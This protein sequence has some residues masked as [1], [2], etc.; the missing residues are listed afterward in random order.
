MLPTPPL[1]CLLHDL[2]FHP[3]YVG[4]SGGVMI[5]GRGA[6]DAA[7]IRWS[8]WAQTGNSWE[9]WQ[10]RAWSPTRE[11]VPP[12]P[13]RRGAERIIKPS[14]KTEDLHGSSC[15]ASDGCARLTGGALPVT[16][17]TED[18]E[19]KVFLLC[20]ATRGDVSDRLSLPICGGLCSHAVLLGDKQKALNC[21]WQVAASNVFISEHA[22]SCW[23]SKQPRWPWMHQQ[24]RKPHRR[25]CALTCKRTRDVCS[26][27]N[28]K[29][30]KC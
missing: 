18:E 13:P 12:P 30:F 15:D 5:S 6:A 17:L 14:R 1:F 25:T 26:V 24:V 27:F 7:I 21:F 4:E 10:R 23:L 20:S 2:R 16:R 3:P 8:Q 22:H 9:R 28:K 19:K 29:R 11:S